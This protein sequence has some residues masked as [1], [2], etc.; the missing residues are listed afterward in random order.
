MCKKSTQFNSPN[1]NN[2]NDNDR[3]LLVTAFALMTNIWASCLDAW[4]PIS[5]WLGLQ[6][7]GFLILLCGALLYFEVVRL[8]RMN[9]DK[10]DNSINGDDHHRHHSK[11]E[12]GL[13]LGDHRGRRE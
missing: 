8:P 2:N 11:Q 10:E 13:L 12:K 1:K 7:F 5:A 3:T 4:Q 9:Y 6:F